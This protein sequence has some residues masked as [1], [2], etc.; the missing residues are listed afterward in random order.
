MDRFWGNCRLVSNCELER[1]LSK[2]L[3]F[4]FSVDHRSLN[5]DQNK[6]RLKI[7]TEGLEV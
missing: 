6:R 2:D 1:D 5:S 4:R 7:I 3:P